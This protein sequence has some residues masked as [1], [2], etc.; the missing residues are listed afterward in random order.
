MLDGQGALGTIVSYLADDL[1]VAVF[2]Y[3]G[4]ELEDEFHWYWFDEIMQ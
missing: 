3:D 1:E 4:S 2:R